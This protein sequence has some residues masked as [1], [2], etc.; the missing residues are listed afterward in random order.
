DAPLDQGSGK[1]LQVNANTSFTNL[2]L[3]TFRDQDSLNTL[4]SDYKGTISWGDGKTSAVKFV[5][6]GSTFNVG[7]FWKVQ[8]SHKYSSKKTYTVKIT[9]FD[10]ASPGA[11]L[12]ITSTI[13]VV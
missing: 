4:P 10:T 13:K 9:L 6:N 12:T 2:T 7:S 3:G 5:F 1:S 8:G 11:K